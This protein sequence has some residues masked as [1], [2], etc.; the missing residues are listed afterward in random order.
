[1]CVLVSY[2]SGWGKM[3]GYCER[4]NEDDSHEVKQILLKF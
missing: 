2:G 4:E 1:M 3:A